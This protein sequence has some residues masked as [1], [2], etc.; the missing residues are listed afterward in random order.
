MAG[1]QR[2]SRRGTDRQ[3]TQITTNEQA[4]ADNDADLS[5]PDDSGLSFT[6]VNTLVQDGTG[7]FDLPQHPQRPTLPNLDEEFSFEGEPMPLG[8]LTDDQPEDDGELCSWLLAHLKVSKYN[9]V[10]KILA[11]QKVYISLY[12]ADEG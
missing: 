4:S 1:A 10:Q 9:D 2:A 5:D 12:G 3:K 11:K 7:H 6:A 8:L